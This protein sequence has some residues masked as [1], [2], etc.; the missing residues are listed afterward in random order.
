MAEGRQ[1]KDMIDLRQGSPIYAPATPERFNSAAYGPL[2][3][4]LASRLIDP[5]RPDFLQL[6]LLSMLATLGLAAGCALLAYRLARSY[7]AAGP[8]I[9]DAAG[10]HLG[11][12]LGGCGPP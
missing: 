12:R 3:Y 10:I 2:F 1:L 6:R 5:S 9:S 11:H 4:L 8:G 7:L